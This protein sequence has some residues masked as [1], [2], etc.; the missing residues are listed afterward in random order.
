MD[1]DRSRRIVWMIKRRD[2]ASLA[3][4]VTTGISVEGSPDT[5]SGDAWRD[6]H[7]APAIGFGLLPGDADEHLITSDDLKPVR[8]VHPR[9]A[10]RD[11]RRRPGWPEVH[12]GRD[13]LAVNAAELIWRAGGWTMTEGPGAKDAPPASTDEE[14]GPW[15]RDPR[16]LARAGEHLPELRR[17]VSE[18]RTLRWSLGIGFLV[19]LAAHVGGYLLRSSAT[20]EPLGLVAE[21]L[22]TLGWALWT[23]IGVVWVVVIVFSGMAPAPC[24]DSSGR[25]EGRWRGG[26]RTG[27]PLLSSP[28]G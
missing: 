11:H 22:Y 26:D 23:E 24:R 14:L 9:P 25:G 28:A 20:T 3:A 27:T 13:G 17:S 7:G 19:G 15:V 5:P 6:G 16:L 8:L 21:L 18:Q 1:P 10:R 4:T 12:P 2:A